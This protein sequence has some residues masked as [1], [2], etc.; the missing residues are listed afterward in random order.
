MNETLIISDKCLIPVNEI[1]GCHKSEVSQYP[2]SYILQKIR[3]YYAS[4]N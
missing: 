4:V 2:L 3:E 1:L